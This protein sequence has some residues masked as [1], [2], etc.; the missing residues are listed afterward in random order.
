MQRTIHRGR[1]IPKGTNIITHRKFFNSNHESFAILLIAET[2]IEGFEVV[3]H[4]L[5][6][7]RYPYRVYWPI[8]RYTK[9]RQWSRMTSALFSDNFMPEMPFT[10]HSSQSFAYM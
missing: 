5:V 4:I 6:P 3:T 2:I 8:I 1:A 9:A 10:M 7:W